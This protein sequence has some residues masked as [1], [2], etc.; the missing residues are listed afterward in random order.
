LVD[1]D[2]FAELEN[3]KVMQYDDSKKLRRQIRTLAGHV[4]EH[5]GAGEQEGCDFA[6]V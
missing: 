5:V 6:Q 3:S 1:L 4:I 2:S